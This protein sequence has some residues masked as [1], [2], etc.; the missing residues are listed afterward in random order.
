MDLGGPR[1]QGQT[2]QW[3]D[4]AIHTSNACRKLSRTTIPNSIP[5]DYSH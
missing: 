4:V 2:T 5:T 3:E 1:D